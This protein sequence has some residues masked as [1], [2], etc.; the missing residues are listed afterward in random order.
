MV[1]AGAGTVGLVLFLAVA[2]GCG[3]KAD[4]RT[5]SPPTA[6]PSTTSPSPDTSGE[7]LHVTT[8][9]TPKATT[10]LAG[11]TVGSKAFCPGGT[12]VDRHGNPDIGLVDRTLT[13]SDG[14]LRMGFDPGM[15]EGD[16]QTGPWRILSGTGAYEGWT[17][18]GTM[19]VRYDPGAADPEHPQD[20]HEEFTGKVWP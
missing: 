11:S 3:S 2:T 15:P 9:L 17:G 7:K 8:R 13:C 12:A 16:I 20:G 1:R 4:T 18:Q 14:T 5:D 10:V 19:V 6:R